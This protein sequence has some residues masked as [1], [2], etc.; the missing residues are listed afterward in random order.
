MANE[1]RG[2]FLDFI[3]NNY[4]AVT[5]I[6]V[7]AFIVIPIPKLLIDLLMILNLAFAFVVLLAVIYT[8]RASDFQT[9]PRI[10]LFQTILGMGINIA[11]TTNSSRH[12]FPDC[13][14]KESK[15]GGNTRQGKGSSG[16]SKQVFRT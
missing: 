2:K 10:I 13:R 5:L 16:P 9:F 6:I 1:S 11:S 4:V 15:R 14:T 8:P 12:G 3:L 7:I